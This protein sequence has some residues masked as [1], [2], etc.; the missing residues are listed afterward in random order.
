[1]N[2]S[3]PNTGQ[4]QLL[5][6]LTSFLLRYCPLQKFSFLDF[7][8][9]SIISFRDIDL[10]FRMLVFLDVLYRSISTFVTFDLLLLQL[11]PFAKI[12]FSG[13]FSPV[14][15]YIN[16]KFGILI[17]LDIIQIKF[18]FCNVWPRSYCTP[19]I[20]FCYNSVFW[21]F[22]CSLFRYWHQ[23]AGMNLYWHNPERLW[24]LY[25]FGVLPF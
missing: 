22:L 10:E 15:F 11:L 8:Y 3:R 24:L 18:D 2:L 14:F 6:R 20:S 23:V 21:T 9:V 4:G 1:M 13:L 17:C 19:V 25:L 16:L 12:Y 5:L 7:A